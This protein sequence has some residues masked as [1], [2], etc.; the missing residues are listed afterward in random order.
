MAGF[1]CPYCNQYFTIEE[2][3][4]YGMVQLYLSNGLAS[5]R[6][7]DRKFLFELH[8]YRCPN[9]TCRKG[10][11]I[12]KGD[13]G[14]DFNG[15]KR[16]LLPE[17]SRTQPPSC[18]PLHIQQDYIEAS[19]ICELSPKASATLSRRCLQSMIRDFWGISKSNLHQEIEALR[20]TIDDEVVDT[21]LAVKSIGNIGAHPNNNSNVNTILD[22]ETDEASYL[23]DMIEYLIDDWYVSKEKKKGLFAH[24]R[25]VK[26]SKENQKSTSITLDADN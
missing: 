12:L 10:T 13:S 23:L 2:K 15:I 6:N 5:A 4:N 20:G 11:F 22:I 24:L 8:T 26:E 3:V 9:D 25:E 17:Y 7:D 14:C 1:K 21:L 19:S 16:Q 18:V